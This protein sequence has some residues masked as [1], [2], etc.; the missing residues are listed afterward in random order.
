MNIEEFLKKA[1]KVHKNKYDYSLINYYKNNKEK[2]FINCPIHGAFSQ[3]IDKH[4]QGS[5]CPKCTKYHNRYTTEE[6]INKAKLM[7]NGKYDYSKVKY[8]N[9]FTKVCIICPEHGEFWQRPNN[10]LNGEGCIKCGIIRGHDLQRKNTE[11]FINKAMLV[12][13]NKYNY[14]KVDY[15]DNSTNVCITCSK[16]GDFWQKP[17]NHLNG[18]GCPI[19]NESHLERQTAKYLDYIN[20]IYKREKNWEWLK[21]KKPLHIDFYLPTYNVIIECQGKQHFKEN[22]SFGSKTMSSEDIYEYVNLIDSIKSKQCSENGV[23][24]EYINYYD[25][26]EKRINEIIEKYKNKVS[27]IKT[28]TV[29]IND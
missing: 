29:T 16:H 18:A 25:N 9:A 7:H 26:V 15:I 1:N 8:V 22:E 11:Q 17:N 12:H 3:R 28:P 24:I 13:G 23:P 14:D 27:E 19:C 6:W 21:N 20:V 2:V 5:G 4:L 10:H